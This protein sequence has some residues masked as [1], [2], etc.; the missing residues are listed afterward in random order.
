MKMVAE[1]V[2]TCD[3]A[4]TLGERFRVELPIIEQMHAVL[5]A[6]KSPA[7]AIRDLMERSLKSE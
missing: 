3:A 1:G 7:E 2:E 5:R 4:M 6:S